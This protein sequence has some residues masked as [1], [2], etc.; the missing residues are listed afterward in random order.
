MPIVS[1]VIPTYNRRA[2]LMEAV[3]SVRAQTFADWELLVADDG[4]TDGCADALEALRDPRIRV[5]RL[6]HAGRAAAARNAGVR[7][8][9]GEWV[10]FLDSD[11][12]WEPQKLA[13]QL[14]LTR[15]A[16]ARWSYTRHTLMDPARR[17]VPFRAGGSAAVS[18]RI[19]RELLASE[20]GAL[21]TT[22]MVSRRLLEEV[23]G[24]DESLPLRDDLDLELR[25]AACEP[26]LA[27]DQVLTRV[28]EHSGRITSSADSPH[29]A[30]FRVYERFLQ[31]ER[32]PALRRVAMEQC[33]R[34]LVD[35]AVYQAAHRRTGAALRLLRRSLAYDPPPV[36]W[37]RAA[38]SVTLRSLGLRR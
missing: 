25:L 37:L 33:A 18:G 4:S 3:D 29:E 8:A 16:G 32:D 27:V 20:V 38:A 9:R 7:S 11:D 31:R 17:P 12:L 34:L 5:L 22:M 21:I 15:A 24:F 6:P 13:V 28:R 10:A 26:V 35:G 30:T 2:L 19:L 1:V 23:G 14:D 36:R